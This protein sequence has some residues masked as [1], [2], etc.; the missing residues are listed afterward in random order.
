M[1][2]ALS[3]LLIVVAIG[4]LVVG[5]VV[6]TGDSPRD[7]GPALR[8][9]STDPEPV[10]QTAAAAPAQD[11]E[12]ASDEPEDPGTPSYLDPEPVDDELDDDAQVPGVAQESEE[13]LADTGPLDAAVLAIIAAGVIASGGVVNRAGRD[14]AAGRLTVWR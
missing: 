9:E 1:S 7:D 6:A 3:N 10:E 2:R 14:H 4:L 13:Q 11:D 12:A 5:F 8:I